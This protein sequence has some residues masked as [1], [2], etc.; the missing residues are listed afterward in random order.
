MFDLV[1]KPMDFALIIYEQWE[2]L[3]FYCFNF[4][5]AFQFYFFP[6]HQLNMDVYR[7]YLPMCFCVLVYLSLHQPPC[8][9]AR[10]IPRWTERRFGSRRRAVTPSACLCLFFFL[11]SFDQALKTGRFFG[12]ESFFSS[13]SLPFQ[14][15][16]CQICFYS[17]S[18]VGYTYTCNLRAWHLQNQNS[19]RGSVTRLIGPTL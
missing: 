17:L 7:T 13:R 8:T 16:C 10:S 14:R 19:S 18:G 4:G 12:D 6:C 1:F 9:A 3:D 2:Q 11:S 15:D 5:A